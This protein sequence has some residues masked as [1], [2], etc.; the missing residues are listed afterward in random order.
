M[1]LIIYEEKGLKLEIVY[2]KNIDST[3]KFLLN[4]LSENELQSPI[5]VISEEQ[6]AGVGTKEREWIG[7]RGNLFLSFAIKKNQLPKDLPLNSISIYF[8][9]V[10]KELLSEHNSQ[11]WLKWPNDF[12]NNDK[13]IGGVLTALKGENIICS[14]GL[15]LVQSPNNFAILDIKIDKNKLIEEFFLKVKQV[16]LWKYVFSKYKI[17]FE[18]SKN[19]YTTIENHKKVSLSDAVLQEDGSIMINNKKVFSLR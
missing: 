2:L 3:H 17:E 5:A 14:I 19:Y 15:N 7:Y 6:T 18:K 12:Y 8:A 10:L 1:L 11:V 13:K 4:K 9:Y 16:I